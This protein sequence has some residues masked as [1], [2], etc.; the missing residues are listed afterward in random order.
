MTPAIY[1]QN[2]V[3]FKAEVW[4]HSLP[5]DLSPPFTATEE[6][7]IRLGLNPAAHPGEVDSCAV[8]LFGSLR[9]RGTTADQ[10]IQSFATATWAAREL[11]AA[12]G[13][14]VDFGKYRGKT[15]GEVPPDYLQ[16]AIKNCDN[17]SFNLRR[18]MQLVLNQGFGRSRSK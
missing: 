13:R 5:D 12:R 9:K 4:T 1:L 16:W 14:I 3:V 11:M 8:K 10:V 18:A 15:V 7:L 2:R 6:K 17:M